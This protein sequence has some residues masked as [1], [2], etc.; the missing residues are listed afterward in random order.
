MITVL[1]I[2]ASGQLGTALRKSVPEGVKLIT[3][4][5]QELDLTNLVDC[6]NIVRT[7]N[8]HWLINAAAYTAVDKAEN[9]PDLAF[10]INA[11]APAE[12]S[13]AIKDTGARMLQISTDYVFNGLQ[14][15][16]YATN[17]ILSPLGAYGKSKAAAEFSIQENL[18]NENRGFV[19]RT[20]WLYGPVGKNFMHTMLHL[21]SKNSVAG[22]P[23]S[24]IS[25]QIGCPTSTTTLSNVCW[26]LID[27]NQQHN[28][29]PYLFHCSDAG[30]A[31]WYDFALAIGEIG[32]QKGLLNDAAEVLPITT[33]DYPTLAVRPQY[34]LLSILKSYELL[35]I[36]PVH[37]RSSLCNVLTT[38]A[39]Q[40][41]NG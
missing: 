25:D 22:I 8:P 36:K 6:R 37:W 40:R 35:G 16:P 21:H 10:M 39:N 23:V 18:A 19:I 3:P 5:R 11:H 30:A 20:S 7:V 1:L 12:F 38:L 24:V 29:L 15:T 2:G 26:R 4:S 32:V 41:N 9:E 28:Q 27:S 31:S 14:S 17:H 33:S 34:S 13:L